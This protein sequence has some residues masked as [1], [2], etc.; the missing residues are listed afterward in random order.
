VSPGRRLFVACIVGLV[1]GVRTWLILQ[2]KT[3]PTD[4]E[5]VWFAARA[6][7]S[8]HDAYQL[9]GPGRAFA[10]DFFFRYPLTAAVVAV[11]VSPLPSDLASGLIV[12]GGMASLAWVLM[13]HGH[14]PLIGLLSASAISVMASVQWSPLFAAATVL[15]PLGILFVAKPTIGFAMFAARPS[16][17]AVTGGLT[18]TV[19]AFLVQPNWVAEWRAALADKVGI[20]ALVLQPGGALALLALI[21]WRR[22]EAR[23]LAVLV[24]VPMTPALYEMVPL[25]LIPRR[26]WEAA[27]LVL[28]SYVVAFWA[29]IVPLQDLSTYA[30]NM[31]SSAQA[32]A[33]VLIPLATLLVLRRPNDGTIPAW[34]ERRLSRWPDWLRGVSTPHRS[35]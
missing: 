15:A 34:M 23:M 17:W 24:C 27:L 33:L 9:I 5:Q 22:P 11:P 30:S 12:G 3:H 8:G 25:L 2:Q 18:A 29:A 16:W 14:A 6:L 26:W 19:I 32:N 28:A 21:R 20:T 1:C 35:S 4:F 7:L 31:A 10:Y 13:R